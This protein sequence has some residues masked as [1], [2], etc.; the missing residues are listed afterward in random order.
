MARMASIGNNTERNSRA[1]G[2]VLAVVQAVL[3]ASLGIFGKLLYATGLGSQEV[4]I[5]RFLCTTVLLGAFV[6]VRGKDA[7]ISRQKTVYVQAVFFFLSAFLYF[8]TVEHLTAGMTTVIFYTFPLVVALIN[9]LFFHERLTL[10]TGFALVLALAGLVLVSGVV[11]GGLVLEPF[12]IANAQP[13]FET[14]RM[15][16]TEVTALAGGKHTKLTLAAANSGASKPLYSLERSQFMC[17]TSIC[18]CGRGMSVAII[19]GKRPAGNCENS[20]QVLYF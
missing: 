18:R 9:T 4:V 8:F 13:V 1:V 14:D 20:G 3:Y 19:A 16:I 11:T 17:K 10:A 7:L 6:L 12:G 2:Y 15:L 5:L